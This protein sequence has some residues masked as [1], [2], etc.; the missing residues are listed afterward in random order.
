M[1]WWDHNYQCKSPFF[2][3]PL[4]G[5]VLDTDNGHHLSSLCSVVMRREERV[6]ERLGKWEW[7]RLIESECEDQNAKDYHFNYVGLFPFPSLSCYII[8]YFIIISYSSY[9]ISQLVSD[10]FLSLHHTV[11]SLSCLQQPLT[12]LWEREEER[13][14]SEVE[15]VSLG[16]EERGPEK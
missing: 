7:Q 2:S 12:S 16:R 1:E 8:F 14:R 10:S 9:P 13:K 5:G 3:Q 11:T 4:F 6:S 15:V